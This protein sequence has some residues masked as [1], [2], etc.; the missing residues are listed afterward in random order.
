MRIVISILFTLSILQAQSIN[1]LIE[2]SLQKHHSLKT[3]QHRLSAMDERIEK[4]QNF[5]NPDLSLTINDIQLKKPLDRS[6]EPMQYNA[7]NVT[8]KFPWFGKR[9]AQETFA[10]AQKSVIFHTLKAAQV[11]LAQKIRTTAYT[12]KEFEE[13]IKILSRYLQVVKQNIKLY[14]AYI[15]TDESSHAGSMASE[16]ML[17]RIKIKLERYKA[18]LKSQR[19]T[20]SYLIEGKVQHISESMKIK[21]P[22]PLQ[23]YLAKAKRNP[24]Y[25]Q[26]VSQSRVADANRALKELEI[27]PD[28]YLKVGYFNRQEF[29]EYASITVGVSLPIYGSERL[30]SEAARKEALSAKSASI[31]YR[32][33]LE[34]QIKIMYAKL[35]E[36]YHIYGIIENESLPQL[37]HMFELSQSAIQRGGDL[38]TYTNLLE[39][40]L[41]LEEERT[42]IKAEYLRT[43]AKLKSLIGEI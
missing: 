27:N 41:A 26:R 22:K 17:S 36:T 39:Q 9:D 24:G 42:S 12:I 11:K 23:T 14:T 19:A 16:L 31:D 10:K 1:Q 30:E 8:Q 5:S 37:A 4:S 13:R 25:H 28:P 20:L 43:Q 35:T 40:K 32:A 38:F 6:L 2:Q 29:P 3:I 33:S 34:S 15:S 18:V 21:E 7:I